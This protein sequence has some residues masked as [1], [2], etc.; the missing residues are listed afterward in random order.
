MTFEIEVEKI[1][2][3]Y[4]DSKK[5]NLTRLKAEHIVEN[6]KDWSELS[7]FKDIDKWFFNEKMRNEN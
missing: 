1:L 5:I 3:N 7:S 4:K 6:L 2:E